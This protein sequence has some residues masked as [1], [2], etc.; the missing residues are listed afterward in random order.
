MPLNR[1]SAPTNRKMPA[2]AT[3]LP[4]TAVVKNAASEPKSVPAAETAKTAVTAATVALIEPVGPS[5]ADMAPRKTVPTVNPN[6][7]ASLR[8]VERLGG[9]LPASKVRALLDQL[10]VRYDPQGEL[11]LTEFNS[12]RNDT[13]D[14]LLR[15]RQL[16]EGLG[17]MIVRMYR[18]AAEDHVWRD[19]CVQHFALYYE[20]KWPAGSAQEDNLE[21][22]AI[23]SAYRDALREPNNMPATA[24]I[25]LARL[26]RSYPEFDRGTVGSEALSFVRDE[27]KPPEV[28]TTAMQICA[29]LGLSDALPSARRLAANGTSVPLKL[30][31]MATLGTLGGSMDVRLLE[32]LASAGDGYGRQTAAAA[33]RQLERRL[34]VGV[35]R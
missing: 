20:A 17:L 24:L 7:L 2:A 26:S 25:G 4:V 32:G 29:E 9:D 34:H 28:R 10:A 13:L 12:I 6:Y 31:A 3:L 18:D 8:E 11:C 27:G 1:H 5:P 30:A 22:R 15:Q 21:V 33:L 16:P 19:Y 14:A 35:I 23:Q